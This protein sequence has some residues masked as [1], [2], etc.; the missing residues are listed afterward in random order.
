MSHEFT[1]YATHRL[2]LRVSFPVPGSAQRGTYFLSF[3]LR[4]SLPLLA[5]FATTHT[6][7]SESLFLRRSNTVWPTSFADASAVGETLVSQIGFSILGTFFSSVLLFGLVAFT[8]AI[9]LWKRDWI[10]P[11]TNGNSMSISAACHVPELE[12]G[13]HLEKIR[14][15]VTGVKIKEGEV[16][17]HCAFSSRPVRMPKVGEK[18]L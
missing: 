10:L 11:V 17:G 3:A 6:F 18:F 16:V 7:L 8:L 1:R 9:G 12:Q 4:Y 2:G 5:Y 14:W 13:I 15:G